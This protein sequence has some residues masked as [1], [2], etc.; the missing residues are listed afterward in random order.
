MSVLE[1]N[2]GVEGDER[3]TGQPH[4]AKASMHTEIQPVSPHRLL[5]LSHSICLVLVIEEVNDK[6]SRV[7]VLDGEKVRRDKATRPA[8]SLSPNAATVC[9]VSRSRQPQSAF[10]RT[11]RGVITAQC[12]SGTAP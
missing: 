4:R 2:G 12:Y 7:A 3:M 11:V 6:G 1:R 10:G 9:H 8:I 5:F